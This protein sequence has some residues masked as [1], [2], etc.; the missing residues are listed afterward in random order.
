MKKYFVF[1][2]L[3]FAC[4]GISISSLAQRKKTAMPE[5]GYWVIESNI[6]TPRQGTIHFY[7]NSGQSIG[8]QDFA[9]KKFN[10][11][12]RKVVRQ[13]NDMLFQALLVYRKSTGKEEM[14]F[15]KKQ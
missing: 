7:S 6:K 3:L 8:Q 10:V 2:A 15:A 4:T 13:L 9:D 1:A 5:E 12:K 11:S 14:F